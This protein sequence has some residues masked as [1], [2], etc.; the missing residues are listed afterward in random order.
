MAHMTTIYIDIQNTPLPAA[1]KQIDEILA[2][3]GAR[4]DGAQPAY[5]GPSYTV[6]SA[7]PAATVASI[8]NALGE[9]AQYYVDIR[10]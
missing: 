4:Q 2:A 3:H 7:S 6:D 9:L 5:G 1:L 8:K 10:Y